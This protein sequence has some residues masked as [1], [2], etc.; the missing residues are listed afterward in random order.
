MYIFK[1]LFL[2]IIYTVKFLTVN[3]FCHISVKKLF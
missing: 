2:R 3:N 1:I